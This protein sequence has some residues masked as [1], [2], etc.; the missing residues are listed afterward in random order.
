M[1]SMYSKKNIVQ[2]GNLAKRLDSKVEKTCSWILR[3]RLKI[4]VLVCSGCHN[5]IPS[6]GWTKP[7]KSIPH[8]S[9]GWKA[10][11]KVL[12]GLVFGPLF[13]LWGWSSSHCILSPP[14]VGSGW[15][16][17]RVKKKQKAREQ[18]LSCLF[19][20]IWHKCYWIK[21]PLLWLHLAFIASL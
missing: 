6:T 20:F 9:G 4:W 1:P 21:A 13:L 14:F 18:E 10:K 2:Y 5:Y 8:P 12:A 19:L 11:T 3:M 7:Q 16:S 15:D 17:H